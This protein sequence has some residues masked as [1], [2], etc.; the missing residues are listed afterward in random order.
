MNRADF[1]MICKLLREQSGLVLM[2]DKAYLLE[3]RLLPVAR[4][5]K[6]ATFDDL[7]KALRVGADTALVRDIV[8]AM[9]TNE[10]FFFRDGR[11]FDQI[12]DFILPTLLKNRAANRRIRIWSAA[13]SSGQEPYSVA[14]LLTDIAEA[15]AGW[16]VEIV[17]SDL[18][19]E[20]LARAIEGTYSQFEVQRGLPI[21]RLVKHF[22]QMGD[23]WQINEQIR[24]MVRYREFNLLDDPSSLGRFD[25][26]LCRNVL[27]YLDHETRS[28]VLD[29]I[30]GQM[31]PDGFLFL[32]GA[33]TVLGLTD[34]LQPIDGQRAVYAPVVSAPAAIA[35]AG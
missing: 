25:L 3:S 22:R 19:G 20:M 4:K 11:P 35:A 7:A 12:R 32:G 6:L 31:A 1:D 29:G 33:E 18:S 2:A 28:K 16:N 34:R 26:V 30:A 13:C 23:R 15:L 9:T 10:T 24:G 8:Q 21:A 17:A 27:M 14:I 5:W